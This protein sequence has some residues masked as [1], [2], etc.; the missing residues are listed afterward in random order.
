VRIFPKVWPVILA[1]LFAAGSNFAIAASM[2]DPS[3]IGVGARPLGMGKAF[4]ALAD[5]ANAIFLN[6][7]GLTQLN[8][9]NF[10]SMRASLIGDV[11]YTVL[12]LAM[13]LPAGYFGAGFVTSGISSIP[14]TRWT[15]S[16][17]VS[18]PE[19]Y[20]SVDYSSS[21]FL[22]SYANR[23]SSVF[24]SEKLKNVSFGATVKYFLQSFSQ[25][26]GDLDGATGSGL[27]L[28]I[29]LR[30][31]PLKWL[32]LGFSATNIIPYSM[33]GRFIWK[34]NGVAEGIP[35]YV[36]GGLAAK[37]T[38]DLT[39]LF[40]AEKNMNSDVQPAL[41]HTGVEWRTNKYL[42]LRA[43]LDQQAAAGSSGMGVETNLTFGIGFEIAPVT[44][45][46]AYHKYGDMS[47]NTTHYF[48]ISLAP[49]AAGPRPVS[50]PPKTAFEQYHSSSD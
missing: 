38:R 21:V 23:L 13:P 48:S 27:D 7:S 24:R 39:V 2:V 5:D 9:L 22:L 45:D 3:I 42:A 18:R 14:L 20:S 12:G 10:T 4:I 17:G 28:D 36:K 25:T 19:V 26:T 37:V 41:L 50:P 33:G 15:T 44:F 31:S 6:P 46:Y 1:F 16:N 32:D 35:A 30:L 34:K 47:E 40:D 43:G 8:K 11:D 49:A 29:G